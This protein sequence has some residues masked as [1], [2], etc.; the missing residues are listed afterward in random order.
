MPADD[1]K[2]TTKPAKEKKGFTAEERAAIRERAKEQKAAASREEG[3]RD[4]LE[5][6]AAMPEP[7]RAMAER[8][9]ALITANAPP[10]AP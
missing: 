6:I 7:D 1:D 2:A 3:E 8:L 5:K 10:L 4:L 9:H